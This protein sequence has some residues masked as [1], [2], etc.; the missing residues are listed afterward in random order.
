MF[1]QSKMYNGFS[2][3]EVTQKGATRLSILNLKQGIFT[4]GILM[5]M[6]RLKG[7]A[8]LEPETPIYPEDLEAWEKKAG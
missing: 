2:Q 7:V 5:D 1:Y 8:Y 4:R 3:E 6:A